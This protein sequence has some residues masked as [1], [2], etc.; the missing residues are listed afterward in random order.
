MK[1]IDFTNLL[2]LIP[3][4]GPEELRLVVGSV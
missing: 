4:V 1:I 3:G 2:G